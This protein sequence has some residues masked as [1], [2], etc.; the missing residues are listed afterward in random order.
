MAEGA[1]DVGRRRRFGGIIG[2]LPHPLSMARIL[3]S[4][5]SALWAR[6]R[7]IEAFMIAEQALDETF[8]FLP[9]HLGKPRHA[10]ACHRHLDPRQAKGAERSWW[11]VSRFHNPITNAPIKKLVASRLSNTGICPPHSAATVSIGADCMA[12]VAYLPRNRV[13]TA[14]NGTGHR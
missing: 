5:P 3:A 8:K 13:R 12:G 2:K 7:E 4:T 11:Q 6:S 10:L 9:P 1:G 14:W